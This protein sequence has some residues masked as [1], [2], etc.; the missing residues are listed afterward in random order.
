MNGA[1]FL[2]F[3]AFCGTKEL[4]VEGIGLFCTFTEHGST[5]VISVVRI[6]RCHSFVYLFS[7][8]FIYFLN[9]VAQKIAPNFEAMN[10]LISETLAFPAFLDL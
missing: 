9:R 7:Y 3:Y 10:T 8:L 6:Q 5:P 2:M 4:K 1:Q